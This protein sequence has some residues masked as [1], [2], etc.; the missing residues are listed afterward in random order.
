MQGRLSPLMLIAGQGLMQN[1]G[2]GLNSGLSSAMSAYTGQ[3]LVGSYTSAV[4][5]GNANDRMK[6]FAADTCPA[7]TNAIPDGY[8]DLD[9]EVEQVIASDG[10]TILVEA[11][12]EGNDRMTTIVSRHA[13][14]V[15]GSGDLSKFVVHMFTS[16]SYVQTAGDF[17]DGANSANTYLGSTFE[18]F[19][20]L[21]TGGI[22]GISLAFDELGNDVVGT[23]NAIDFAN[24]QHY[25]TPHSLMVTFVSLGIL[26]FIYPELIAQGVNPQA[27]KLKIINLDKSQQLSLVVQKKCYEAFKTITGEKL[28]VIKAILRITSAD[29][30]TLADVLDTYKLF[31]TSRQTLTSVTKNGYRGIY[32]NDLGSVNEQFKNL[33]KD[34]YSIMPRNICDANQAFKRSLQQVKNVTEMNSAAL[35]NAVKLLETNYGLN[36]INSLSQPLPS[37][38][39]SYYMNSFASGSGENGRYYLSDF[40]GSVAGIDITENFEIVNTN[41][42]YLTEQ[43]AL[44]DISDAF[45]VLNDMLNGVYGVP[46]GST[47]NPIT[48]PGGNAGAGSY[49]SY[50]DAADSILDD[51]EVYISTLTTNYPDEVGAMNTA[52]NSI[53]AQI[54]REEDNLLL[55]GV[56]YDDT[57]SS[58]HSTM[59][60]V[61]NLHSYAI[62]DDYRGV[63]EMLEKMADSSR[64]GQA[65]VGALREGRNLSRLGTVGVGTDALPYDVAQ[66]TDSADISQGKYSLTEALNSVIL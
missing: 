41:L 31:P 22:S 54:E 53:A 44:D 4:N 37:D 7:L 55:A 8:A 19:D 2:L 23:G 5:N 46:D 49:A 35:G 12:I 58:P 56:V 3:T 63:A 34:Y 32:V 60:L 1:T 29:V 33:G 48:I 39:Y 25:G 9:P 36:D 14:N 21:I 45:V 28:D 65:L 51:V 59:S 64:A 50:S 66:P 15:L 18:N 57:P 6:R 24:L 20:I 30:T 27:T 42:D 47:L 16:L 43:G 10:S 62:Q 13:N 11:Q 17:I 26:E 40:I 38:T 52:M 61:E